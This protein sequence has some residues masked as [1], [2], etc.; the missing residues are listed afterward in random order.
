MGFLHVTRWLIVL[1]TIV[2][3]A[4]AAHA[5]TFPNRTIRIIV[6]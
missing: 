5:E 6:T 1:L 3:I 2:G 4:A